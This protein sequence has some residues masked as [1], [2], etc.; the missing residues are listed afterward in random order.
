VKHS[1]TL[2]Y[3]VRC[4]TAL[5]ESIFWEDYQPAPNTELANLVVKKGVLEAK[6]MRF[7]AVRGIEAI[8][9]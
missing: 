6:L 8:S 2:S 5:C 3:E 9:Q 7:P 4:L 1:S